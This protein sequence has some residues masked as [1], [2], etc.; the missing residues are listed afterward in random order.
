MKLITF[1]TADGKQF[2]GFI[3]NDRAIP[4]SLVKG[5]E[6]V[7]TIMDFIKEF[8]TEIPEQVNRFNDMDQG[9]GLNDMDM[10]FDLK[11]VKL[12][13]P[14]TN[15]IRNIIC[16]GKNYVEHVIEIRNKIQDISGLPEF[17]IYF[18]KFAYPPT[19]HED[20]IHLNENAT[21]NVD[22]E[23]EL[24]IV[25]GKECKNITRES[26][27]KFIFGYTIINDVSA[28][29]IQ[30]RH[31]QWFKGKNLDGF[32]PI[33]PCIEHNSSIG[34]AQNLNIT[35]RVNGEIRQNSNTKNMIFDIAY[36][37]E[38][39]SKTMTL[40]PGDIISTGTPEGVGM[41]FEPPKYLKENDIVE[42][43]I[44]NIGILKNKFIF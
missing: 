30:R 37:I 29:D 39:L 36:I 1:R 23:A 15:P 14:I 9:Y 27:H 3:M 5:L 21:K 2:S 11:D 43:E 26:A 32:C 42:C 6:K 33:G 13:A 17:P 12:L 24:A 8:G 18:S 22:Y 35:C 16:L 40:Y 20:E 25:I 34:N 28:R 44:E 31:V 38:D 7:D 41:G 10:G 19:G 4:F